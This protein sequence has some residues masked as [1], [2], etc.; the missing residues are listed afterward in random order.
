MWFV[1]DI[2]NA[3]VACIKDEVQAECFKEV[4]FSDGSLRYAFDGEYSFQMTED[5]G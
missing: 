2:N 5:E 4:Y 1:L 3:I